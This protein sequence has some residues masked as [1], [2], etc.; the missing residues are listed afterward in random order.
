M[1]MGGGEVSLP[2]Y[3]CFTALEDGTF[4]L[5]LG[6]QVSTSFISYIEY[7]IDNG[8][9]WVRT[10]NSSSI[11]TITTP[12]VLTGNCVYW[13]GSGTRLSTG[14]SVKQYSYFASAGEFDVSGDIASLLSPK[15][16]ASLTLNT[17]GWN[18]AYLFLNCSRL[19]NAEGLIL[20]QTPSSGYRY[21]IYYG[22]F[23]GC[24]SL[25]SAPD[26]SVVGSLTN[27]IFV[28]AFSGCTS[29][30]IAPRL[31]FMT[32]SSECYL[33]MFSGCS[34]LLTTPTLPAT[35]LADKCY[36]GMFKNCSLVNN[37]TG[38]AAKHLGTES[39]MD[40]FSGCKALTNL[41]DINFESFT[42][43]SNCRTMFYNCTALVHCPIKSIPSTVTNSCFYLCFQNCTNL[44][45]IFPMPAE[46]L[47]PYCYG[48]ILIGNKKVNKI[49]MLATDISASNCVLNMSS[50]GASS[51]I[52][53]K[54][55]NAT[56][57]NSN[58]VHSGWTVIYYEPAEDKY[59]TSQD[60]SQECDDYGNPI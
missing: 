15:N 12:V 9:T 59:Y 13:R 33:S 2:N 30:T 4:T 52:F 53:I 47:V 1:M 45:D 41:N 36:K 25:V 37:V 7:S 57:S 44:T 49:K 22:I 24:S 31:D 10:Q 29:L 27:A 23:S 40:M 11:V 19:I 8:R 39:C 51:G 3:L 56:W 58:V 14:T 38:F 50:N 20:H 16:F 6:E 28:S 43:S 26:L 34:A 18:F 55:I 35:T 32:L 54:N 17:S 42:G 21:G 48:N 46:V 60:K 5:T